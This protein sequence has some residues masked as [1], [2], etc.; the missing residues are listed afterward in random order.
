MEINNILI[1]I[2]V[3]F[4]F[5]SAFI[6]LAIK[7]SKAR[8]PLIIFTSVALIVTS[9]WLLK[10]VLSGGPIELT[11]GG[12]WNTALMVLDFI[13]M[14][15]FLY[16]GIVKRHA[17][18]IGLMV[19]QLVFLPLL[20]F[21]W[22]PHGFKVEPTLYL[23]TLSIILCLIISIIGSLI[24]V[25]AIGYMRNHEAHLKL[26]R[27]K[28]HWFFFFMVMFLGAMN[29]LVFA[30]NLLWLYFFW[31]LTTLCCY[32]LIYHDATSEAKTSAIRALWMNLI[33]GAACVGA[34]ILSFNYAGTLSIQGILD[35]SPAVAVLLLPLALLCL[36]AF[37]KS[38]QVPWQSWLLGAMV[39][40]TPVSALLHSSTMVKAG[41]YLVIR[42][43]P[44]FEGTALSTSIAVF[45]AFVFIVTAFLAISQT[46]SKRLLAYSTIG[47]LG[48]IICL[49]GVNTPL[50]ITAAI[51]II[52]FHAISKGLMFLAVGAIDHHIWSRDI[53][54]MQGLAAKYP[55][56]AGI[57]I[58]GIITM[59]LMPF[60]LLVAKWAGFEAVA[61][62]AFP[63]MWSVVILVF[64]IIGCA[65]STFFWIKWMGRLLSQVPSTE[66]LRAERIGGY[67]Y[68]VLFILIAAA[69]VLSIGI[70][71]LVREL[72]E[73]AATAL[74]YT[75]GLDYS[76]WYL[77]STLG[78]FAPWPLAALLAVI[79]I[80]AGFS[81][82]LKKEEV[83][84]AYMCGEN[85]DYNVAKFRAVAD[86][87]VDL[88]TG[89]YYLEKI[90]GEKTLNVWINS[91]GIVTMLVLFALVM[92]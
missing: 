36:T 29:G 18:I 84:P 79:F 56:L 2:A 3:L 10:Q 74:G 87:E 71:P 20:E 50:A 19:L 63:S 34:M 67:Y 78:L 59:L 64:L 75:A 40:P 89:G 16:I 83:R 38:A 17:L 60:G 81:T 35:Q 25:Y 31:E 62:P 52:I 55:V 61:S 82:R 37:T 49:A 43:A 32:Q 11:L 69:I 42:L 15:Y 21:G 58:T 23:D 9:V 86:E 76:N 26:A 85:L 72:V 45:G 13:L 48:L 77:R 70:A 68:P 65:V 6:C 66:P 7:N 24:C 91:I 30:N 14:A 47:N 44:G 12:G 90:F 92:L 28:Q 53:E 54:P 5:L 8:A 4:P 1:G 41:V 22:L 39:A 33:G 88:E 27:T 73:P 46:S 57:T 51:A 80:T